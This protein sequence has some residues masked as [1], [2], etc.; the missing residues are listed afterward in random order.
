MLELLLKVTI[1]SISGAL[2]PGP[3]TAAIASAGLKK[4]WKAGIQASL[5]HTVVELPLVILIA[6]GAT[7]I[8]KHPRA[9]FIIGI[10]GSGFLLLFGLL[11]IRDAFLTNL[12]ELAI[13]DKSPSPI[14]IGIA[15]TGLNP[16]FIIW[17]IGIG[18]PLIAEAALKA[19]IF[20]II[21]LYLFHIWLDYGWLTLVA[22]FASL[23]RVRTKLYRIILLVLGVIIIWFGINLFI[24]TLPLGAQ[25]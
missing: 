9:N 12:K 24:K 6:L 1:I 11:T 15:L 10:L 2:A 5:G 14:I 3:L 16:Y 20:G 19:G 23:G 17:W 4:G 22:T 18:T 25:F 21:L 7:T 13:K 8:F